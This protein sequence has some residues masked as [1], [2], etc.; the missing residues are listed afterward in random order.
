MDMSLPDAFDRTS[1][2]PGSGNQGEQTTVV[3]K[4]SATKNGTA[5]STPALILDQNTHPT[6]S[7]IVGWLPAKEDTNASV[8]YIPEPYKFASTKTES[9]C[10]PNE[11]TANDSGQTTNSGRKGLHLPAGWLLGMCLHY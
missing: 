7:L 8:Q 4:D 1:Q 11:R 10:Q 3:A 2:M 6:T 5:P 9:G